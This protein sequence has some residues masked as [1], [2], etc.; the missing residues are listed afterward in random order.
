MK[1]LRYSETYQDQC[2][3]YTQVV[4]T[5]R[6]NSMEIYPWGPVKFGLYKQGVFI[7]RWSSEQV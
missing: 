6:F 2:G 3:P 5:C 1:I 4:F 7:Y